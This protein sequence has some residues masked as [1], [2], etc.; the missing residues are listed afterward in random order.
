M[1][2][3]GLAR[4][5]IALAVVLASCGVP[6]DKHYAAIRRDDIPFGIADTTTTSTTTTTVSPATTASAPTTTIPT[7]DVTLYYIVNQKLLPV[8]RTLRQPG[9]QPVPPAQVLA[10][11]GKGPDETD[12]PA[13]LRSAIPAGSIGNVAASGGVATV[14]LAPSFVQPTPG[15]TRPAIAPIDQALAFGQIVLTLTS[16]PGIGQVKFTVG[17]QPV[18]PLLSDGSQPAAGTPVSADNYA[19]LRSSP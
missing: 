3:R 4:A 6:S 7:E 10:A 8:P 17:G 16:R 1:T 12:L 14:D 19:G 9:A 5:A 18:A 13:G 2:R 11:L 15:D